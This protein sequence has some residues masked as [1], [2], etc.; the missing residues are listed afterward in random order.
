KGV[1]VVVLPVDISQT[2]IEEAMDYRLIVSNHVICP[3]EEELQQISSLLAQGVKI[4]IFAGQGCHE[5]HDELVQLADLLKA[6]IAY[7]SRAK[8]FV[9]YQNPYIVGMTG[10]F[11]VKSGY[12]ML[13]ECDTLL[14]LGC[15][16]AWADFY[17]DKAKIIQIDKEATH[18]GL[19]YPIE[20]GVVGDIKA[21]LQALLPHI[22]E[23]HERAFVD[24]YTKLYQT[25]M[26]KLDKKARVTESG[27]IHPQYVVE[28]LND[29]ADK[30]AIFTAD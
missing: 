17:P 19:R 12:E 16:F 28:L 18:L 3:N 10:M 29:Y 5:A 11:G 6:H 9:E 24:K 27:M 15:G 7:T 1:A 26:Q 30:D 4:G 22:I 8:D 14:L 23:R 21:S 13:K 20:F 25:T 2:E